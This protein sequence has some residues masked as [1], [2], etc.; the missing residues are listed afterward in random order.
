M[1]ENYIAGDSEFK[2]KTKLH[3]ESW[4]LIHPYFEK[5]KKDKL[6]QYKELYHTPKTS[7]QISEIVCHP[8]TW[9]ASAE[10][11]SRLLELVA[12]VE[13]FNEPV[14]VVGVELE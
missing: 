10:R 3:Q 2:N 6:V 7:Y 9:C 13:V 8:S 1:L 11:P 5:V 4:K 12:E 14:E